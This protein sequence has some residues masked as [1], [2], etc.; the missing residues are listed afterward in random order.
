M[1]RL[2]PLAVAVLCTGASAVYAFQGGWKAAFI[3][4]G[5]AIADWAL[6]F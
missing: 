6:A 2:L 5:F 4:G 1:E 3:W